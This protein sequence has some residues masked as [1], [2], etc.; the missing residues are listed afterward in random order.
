MPNSI[1]LVDT[2]NMNL[3]DFVIPDDTASASYCACSA[4]ILRPVCAV[5]LVVSFLFLCSFWVSASCFQ[6]MRSVLELFRFQTRENQRKAKHFQ[7]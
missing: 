1:R 2:S 5:F 6:A 7:A 4:L 3:T